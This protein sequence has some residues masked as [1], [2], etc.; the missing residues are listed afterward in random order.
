MSSVERNKLEEIVKEAGLNGNDIPAA[1]DL[2]MQMY[3]G[4]DRKERAAMVAS[5]NVLIIF[6]KYLSMNDFIIELKY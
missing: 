4:Q 1:V 5:D 2:E 3:F 6:S